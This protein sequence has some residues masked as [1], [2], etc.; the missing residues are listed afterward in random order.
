MSTPA[1]TGTRPAVL[2]YVELT[3][4]RITLMV[5]ITALVGFVMARPGHLPLG[6]LVSALVGTALVA[7]GASTLN[8]VMERDI[9][10]RMHRTARRPL[11][12]GRLRPR[13]ATAFGIA[14]T[15]CGLGELLWRC[16]PQAAFVALLTWATYLFL[17]TPLKRRTSLSTIV[18]A[19]PGALPPVIG[20][21]AAC[22]AVDPGAFVLFAILFLWQI[23]HFLAIAIYLE[24]DYRRGGLKVFSVER[25]TVTA[26]RWLAFYTVALVAVSLLAQPL[27]LAGFAY[28]LCAAVLG[29]GFLAFAA[30]GVS[31]PVEAG[32]ARRTMLYSIAWLTALMV[33]LV[34][35][36]R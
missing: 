8:M 2:D 35:F 24:A 25:G 33:A 23:P 7:A 3:K 14:I 34:A 20:W 12:A 31:G 26:A 11:P 1:L 4:P 28:T 16:P 30:R 21:A 13:E 19:F 5:V 6:V 27:Q 10:A 9:D 15:V 32:W 36:A 22:G 17:Y 29:A 18:G